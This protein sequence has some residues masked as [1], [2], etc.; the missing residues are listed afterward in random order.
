VGENGRTGPA[1]DA[2]QWDDV[3]REIE[4]TA[5]RHVGCDCRF[6]GYR[7]AGSWRGKRSSVQ[8]LPPPSGAPVTDAEPNL[9][10]CT[11]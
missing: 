6:S 8:I 9:C 1:F 7:V 4:R 3:V 2:A 5:P 11:N 10:V